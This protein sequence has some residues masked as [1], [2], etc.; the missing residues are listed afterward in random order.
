MRAKVGLAPVPQHWHNRFFDH[1]QLL[2]FMKGK[3]QLIRFYDFGLY[4]FLTRVYVPMFASFVGYGANA[5][6]DPIFE[7]SDAAARTA[8]ELFSDRI[9]VSGGRAFGPIQ[10]FV[11]R[12]EA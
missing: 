12:R 3:F 1:E 2:E 8:H 10:V 11:W 6:K 9:K 7:K 5:V 4:Y